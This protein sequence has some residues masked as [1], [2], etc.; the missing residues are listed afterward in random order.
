ME[1]AHPSPSFTDGRG[2]I[3]DVLVKQPI[4]Y[5]TIISSHKGAVRGNH[6]HR[7]TTQWL[8]LLE[9]RLRLLS[10]LPGEP[11][12]EAVL[13][14]G[15]LIVNVPMESHA[16]IALEDA[17]FLVFTRGPR[18]GENYEDDTY[19]LAVPLGDPHDPR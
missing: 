12:H 4:E 19:R 13:E 6:Y 11:V 14:K 16:M 17:R 3:M 15:D 7:D 2:V 9:G 18:G 1:I 10:Q 8:Y 5:V